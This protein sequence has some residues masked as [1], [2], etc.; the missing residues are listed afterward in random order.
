MQLH[1]ERL[2]AGTPTFIFLHG[3]LG[4]GDNWRSVAKNMQLPGTA[5][6]IDLRNHGR[7]PHAST[8]RYADIAQDLLEFMDAEALRSTHILGHSMGGKAAMYMAF[9]FPERIRSIVVVDIAPRAYLGGHEAILEVLMQTSLHV[10]RREDVEKQL[11][12]KIPDPSIRLFLLKNLAR[13]PQGNFYWRL[14]LPTLH[15]EYPHILAQIEGKPYEGPVLFIRGENSAYISPADEQ[16]IRRLFPHARIETIP[17][18]GHWVHVDNPVVLLRV[19]RE[20]WE[21]LG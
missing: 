9:N 5:Y 10:P 21:G 20:F 18:A 3:F 4:S 2:G 8:H 12:E 1:Y 14:N 15:A 6:L 17:G 11:A 19:L 16:D 7:S 13:D